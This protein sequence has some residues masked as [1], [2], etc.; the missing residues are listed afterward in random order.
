MHAPSASCA[1]RS[2]ESVAARSRRS[3]DIL[4][5]SRTTALERCR[6]PRKLEARTLG[7]VG[8]V[9]AGDFPAQDRLT[10][11]FLCASICPRMTR[12]R[13][14]MPA[15]LGDLEAAVMQYVWSEG[16]A[17][18]K[19]V[20]NAL[21]VR[22]G[23]T[24]NT[25]QSAME[26]LYRKGLLQREKVSHAYVYSPG[27]SREEYGG[28]VVENLLS[29]LMRGASDSMLSA[30]VD[31]AARSGQ[32]TLERLESLIDERRRAGLKNRGKV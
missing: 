14:T 21:G 7:A 3:R 9:R 30:F 6:Q 12:E 13:R 24:L 23:I 20:H 27:C 31:F 15:R 25:V 5:A 29:G 11:G 1:R 2:A 26:R 18:V 22:R 4:A 17:D 16:G 10:I 8:R 28:R 19:Q 32:E